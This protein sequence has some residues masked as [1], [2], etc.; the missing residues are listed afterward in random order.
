LLYCYSHVAC[1]A[2]LFLT[3]EVQLDLRQMGQK[4]SDM[5][6]ISSEADEASAMGE[7]NVKHIDSSFFFFCL[8]NAKY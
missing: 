6:Q 5:T 2:I 8:L 7:A 4:P 1:P 3:S